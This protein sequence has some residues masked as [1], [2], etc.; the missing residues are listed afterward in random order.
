MTIAELG[1]I[2]NLIVAVATLSS[3]IYVAIQI[4]D[5]MG[6]TQLSKDFVARINGY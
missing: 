5:K 6:S 4:C 1:D 2:A 3:L